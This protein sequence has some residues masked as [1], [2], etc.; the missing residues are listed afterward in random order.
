MRAYKRERFSYPKAAASLEELDPL[1]GQWE[2]LGHD[3]GI[4]DDETKAIALRRQLPQEVRED[5]LREH[6]T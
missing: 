2:T 5:L 6:D 1:L 3:L 4:V